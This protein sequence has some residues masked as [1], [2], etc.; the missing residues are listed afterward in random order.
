[1]VFIIYSRLIKAFISETTKKA[2]KFNMQLSSKKNEFKQVEALVKS[3]DLNPNYPSAR[4]FQIHFEHMQEQLNKVQLAVEVLQRQMD[5]LLDNDA[6]HEAIEESDCPP[7][8]PRKHLLPLS[9]LV[10]HK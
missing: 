2:R 3:T 5:Q 7:L 10:K 1:L 6:C 9:G 4:Y 8:K